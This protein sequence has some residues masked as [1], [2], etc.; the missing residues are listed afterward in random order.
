M[1]WDERGPAGIRGALHCACTGYFTV[2]ANG[3]N[4]NSL[5]ESD[6]SDA[7]FVFSSCD[8]KMAFQR[9]PTSRAT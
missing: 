1:I 8:T 3:I 2:G 4:P 5:R 9:T 7:N 6:S